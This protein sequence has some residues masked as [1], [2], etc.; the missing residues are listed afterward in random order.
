MHTPLSDAQTAAVSRASLRAKAGVLRLRLGDAQGA[1]ARLGEAQAELEHAVGTE[2]EFRPIHPLGVHDV[3]YEEGLTR[4][5]FCELQEALAAATESSEELKEAELL[6]VREV[7]AMFAVDGVLRKAAYKE[8]LQGIGLWGGCVTVSGLSSASVTR[9]EYTMCAGSTRDRYSDHG[10]YGYDAEGWRQ[11]CEEMGCDMAVGITADAFETM[12]GK[13]RLGLARADLERCNQ[14][15]NCAWRLP[16][17][18]W[19]HA[20]CC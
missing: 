1:A 19:E 5:V 10:K 8:Y 3:G 18:Y 6:L 7:F 14:M 11:E 16:T 13:N 12:Y 20:P 2:A 4:I 15:S 9:T 17:H